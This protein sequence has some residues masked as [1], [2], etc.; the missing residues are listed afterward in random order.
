[1]IRI[2][3]WAAQTSILQEHN[4]PRC[5]RQ[6]VVCDH[7]FSV[8]LGMF[9]LR[10]QF[11]D[12]VVNAGFPRAPDQFVVPYHRNV[13]HLMASGAQDYE[14]FLFRAFVERPKAFGIASVAPAVVFPARQQNY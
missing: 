5:A 13:F 14:G 4:E 6:L 11:T 7:P 8:Q 1:M 2:R 12:N 9:S 3:L 10:T